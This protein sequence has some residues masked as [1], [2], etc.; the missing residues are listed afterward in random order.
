M[1]WRATLQILQTSHLTAKVLLWNLQSLTSVER[2]VKQLPNCYRRLLPRFLP[3]VH[4]QLYNH[5]LSQLA[6]SLQ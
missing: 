2:Q 5:R 6:E 3:Q 1:V 4:P